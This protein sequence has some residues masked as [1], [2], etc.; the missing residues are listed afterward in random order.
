MAEAASME[1]AGTDA[2]TGIAPLPPCC[3]ERRGS[4]LG[5]CRCELGNSCSG[6]AGAISASGGRACTVGN[7]SAEDGLQLPSR[8]DLRE[9]WR[10]LAVSGLPA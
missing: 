5:S 4:C 6:R 1:A 8:R 9:A 10:L 3:K 2:D 7:A